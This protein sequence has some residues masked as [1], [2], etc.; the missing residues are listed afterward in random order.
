MNVERL[1]GER[2][3]R[4][5]VLDCLERSCLRL[6]GGVCQ[7]NGRVREMMEMTSQRLLTADNPLLSLS[8]D[9][10]SS[11]VEGEGGR[12]GRCRLFSH[13]GDESLPEIDSELLIEDTAR[14]DHVLNH[15]P[16]LH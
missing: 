3:E 6:E 4:D 15:C 10:P 7:C 5:G 14:V 2:V 16:A 1:E 13:S 12:G 11:G 8:L 9:C